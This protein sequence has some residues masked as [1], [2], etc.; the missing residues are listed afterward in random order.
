MLE[1]ERGK[2]RE[3]EVGGGGGCVWLN[4]RGGARGGTIS[5]SVFSVILLLHGKAARHSAE[6]RREKERQRENE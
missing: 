1:R 4:E 2:E 3:P 6:G 5:A